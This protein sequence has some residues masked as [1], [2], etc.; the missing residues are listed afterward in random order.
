M[1]NKTPSMKI[2]HNVIEHLGLKLYQ[3][4][5]TN[6]IAE[7]ISNA[8]DANAKHLK[9]NLQDSHD[10][11]RYIIVEDDGCGMDIDTIANTYLVIG[12]AKYNSLEEQKKIISKLGERKPMGRKGIGK[13]APFGICNEI[14]LITVKDGFCN[15]V[16]FD[17]VEMIKVGKNSSV[18]QY[19]P[20][21]IIHN[22]SFS[23][24][25]IT[26]TEFPLMDRVH[27]F[28][29]FIKNKESPSGTLIILTNLTLKKTISVDQ[30]IQSI[31]QRFTV[32]IGRPDFEIMVNGTKVSEDNA[33]PKWELRI[34]N[35]GMTSVNVNV[36]GV[37][38]EIKYWIGFVKEASWPTEHAGIGVYAHGKIAQDRPFFFNVEGREIL[39]RYMYGVIEADLI[40]ELEEDLIST[41]RTSINWENSS[42]ESFFNK[43]Q[44]ITKDAL[45]Q[46]LNH[47]KT[48]EKEK[49]AERI[50]NITS[51]SELRL[52]D[53]EQNYL[54]ELLD[55]VTPKLGKDEEKIQEFTKI[56]AKSWLNEPS[57][58]IV[59]KLW[60]DVEKEDDFNQLQSTL[61]K[62]SSELI[63]QSLNLTRTFAQRVFALT[64]LKERIEEKKETPLQQLLEDFPWIIS[65]TYEK[66]TKR[67]NLTTVVK[68]AGENL[69]KRHIALATGNTKPDFVFLGSA[70]DEDIL[71]IELKDNEAVGYSEFEQLRSYVEYLEQTYSSA[72]V[73][74]ILLASDID[75]K[76]KNK[77]DNDPSLEFMTWDTL[78]KRSRKEYMTFVS[79]MLL[80]A[81]ANPQEVINWGGSEVEEFLSEMAKNDHEIQRLMKEYKSKSQETNL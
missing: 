68:E 54:R 45:I 16:H 32:T 70:N 7:L 69:E 58:R 25:Q 49:N 31:G 11:S 76:V 61:L 72:K 75:T 37:E 30:L 23:N 9:I 78:L 1:P 34:P 38:K 20:K 56:L 18:E 55:E 21:F 24:I 65:H 35:D 79:A 47:R 8:W 60:T 19:Y 62:L 36:N 13:L 48:I 66:F 80:G 59:K 5:P 26:D 27:S 22:Q 74:G 52:S 73:K 4:K 17:Y 67:Q 44:E 81:D 41:D 71:V 64:K 46:Y 42:F 53:T 15:W 40:E 29:E 43:G 28:F 6:V 14:H 51:Q 63:P 39:S 77:I 10:D 3:N 50:K 57:R 2:S 33:L 12:K